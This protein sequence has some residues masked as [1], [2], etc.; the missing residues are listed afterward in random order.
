MGITETKNSILSTH[1]PENEV[2]EN[3]LRLLPGVT[4]ERLAPEFEEIY[5]KSNS[6]GQLRIPHY[7]LPEERQFVQ[8]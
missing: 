8:L 6:G 3:V 1:T 5:V 2:A 4:V 7:G